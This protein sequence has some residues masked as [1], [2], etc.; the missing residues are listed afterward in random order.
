MTT[1]AL[2]T[3][4]GDL[5]AVTWHLGYLFSAVLFAIVFTPPARPAGGWA[6]ARSSRCGLRTS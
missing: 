6:W 5:T 2:G 4:A 3:A 1:F